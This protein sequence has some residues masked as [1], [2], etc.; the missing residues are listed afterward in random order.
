MEIS[1][2]LVPHTRVLSRAQ[3]EQ[4]AIVSD[5]L[6]RSEA[7]HTSV[8]PL[9]PYKD[10]ECDEQAERARYHEALTMSTSS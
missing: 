2:H 1:C 8:F 9:P 3:N 5:H 4:L 6:A 7:Y 10:A